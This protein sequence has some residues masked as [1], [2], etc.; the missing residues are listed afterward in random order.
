MQDDTRYTVRDISSDCLHILLAD[1]DEDDRMFF[2][3]AVN[4]L[5]IPTSIQTVNDGEQLMKQLMIRK[6]HLPDLLFLDLNMPLKNGFEC[7]S[8]IKA[9]EKLNSLPVIIYST[10]LDHE[11]VNILYEKGAYHYIR[12]PGDYSALK[13]V[14]MKALTTI[15][16]KNNVQ[17]NRQNFVIQ[18]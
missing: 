11:V 5:S 17:P 1:D 13:K 10:S 8:A 15:Q 16:D 18:V 12:K 3:D 7:L 4:E 9:H 2:T 14:L 6:E